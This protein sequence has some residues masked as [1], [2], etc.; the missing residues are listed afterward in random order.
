MLY[1]ARFHYMGEEGAFPFNKK[2]FVHP[3][4][5]V[6]WNVGWFCCWRNMERSDHLMECF[7]FVK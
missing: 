1:S 4:V 2:S 7:Q 6:K 3:P 5:F